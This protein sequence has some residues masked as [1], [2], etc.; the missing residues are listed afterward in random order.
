MPVG[1]LAATGPISADL[2]LVFGILLLLAWLLMASTH[3]FRGD[4]VDKPN[5]MA[6]FYGYTVCL[7]AIVVGL[8]TIS[9]I[10]GTTFDRANPLVS[11]NMFGESLSSFGAYKASVR[12]RTNTFQREA[13]DS[14][15]VMSD[16]AL[17][18]QY[19]DR[20]ND[21]LARVRYET[22]KSLVTNCLLLLLAIVLF[23]FHWRW[24]RRANGA[25]P[26]DAA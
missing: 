24:L 4:P 21:R 19:E 3:A 7:L 10:I 14:T 6:Q 25:A 1:Y 12:D 26:P 20:V 18:A 2:V 15:A 11:N 16:A 9:S 22:S 13:R 17:R 8:I 23:G 5:R